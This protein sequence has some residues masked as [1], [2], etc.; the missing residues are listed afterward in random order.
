MALEDE[1]LAAAK[2]RRERLDHPPGGHTS[3]DL[4]IISAPAARALAIARLE[5]EAEDVQREAE[6]A[7]LTAAQREKLIAAAEAEDRRWDKAERAIRHK[8]ARY[9][10]AEL[11]Q[12]TEP[13]LCKPPPKL[14]DIAHAV[15]DYYDV[16]IPELMSVRRTARI[17]RPRQVFCYLAKTLT[18]QSFP[19]IGRHLGNRDHTT[20]LHALNRIAVRMATDPKLA[21]EIAH[22][23]KLLTP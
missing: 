16:T 13:R 22:I 23:R 11:I 9:A 3:T 12:M 18:M 4:D 20:I 17:L 1:I 8:I 10:K 14:R 19:Q 6:L 7:E 2:A 15:A 5:A 21:A